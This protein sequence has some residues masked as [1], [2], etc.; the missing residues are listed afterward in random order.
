MMSQHFWAVVQIRRF[1]NLNNQNA[2]FGKGV[3]ECSEVL[4]VV[5]ERIAEFRLNMWIT[6]EEVIVRNMYASE[7]V[8]DNRR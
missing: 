1:A 8:H 7:Q 4:L 2:I 3:V 6:L 5:V